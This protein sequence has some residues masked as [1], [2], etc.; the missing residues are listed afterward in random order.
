VYICTLKLLLAAV[1]E[2]L[3]APVELWISK[4][5]ELMALRHVLRYCPFHI[6]E[7][8]LPEHTEGPSLASLPYHFHTDKNTGDLIE[9]LN[10][11]SSVEKVF[12]SHI[13]CLYIC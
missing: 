10:A 12:V 11:A 5:M 3:W 1:D 7:V 4:E 8:I 9:V 13:L 6:L 2:I